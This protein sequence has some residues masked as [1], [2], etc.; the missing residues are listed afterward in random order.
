MDDKII[1]GI[2]QVGVGVVD[3]NAAM[4]WYAT[5][6][7]ADVLVFEDHEEATYMAPYMGGKAR[8]KSAALIMNLYGGAGYEVWQHTGRKP[9][10]PEQQILVGDLGINFISIK[11]KD[12]HRSFDLLKA[13]GVKIVSAVSKAP[14]GQLSFFIEDP[15]G[16]IIQVK[17]FLS[18]FSHKKTN[19]GG[20]YSC[21]LGVS[22]IDKTSIL[23]SDILGYNEVV[24][25]ET[26][27]FDD[28]ASLEGGKQKMRRLLLKTK[29]AP[30]G[31]FSELLGESQIELIQVIDRSPK[32][33]FEGRYWGDLGYIHLCFDMKNMPALVKECKEKGFPFSILSN[34]NFDMGD[35]NGDW[36]YLEDPDGTLIEFVQVNRIPILKK[37]NWYINLRNRDPKKPLPRLLVKAMKLNKVKV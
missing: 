16:N 1:Y 35:A 2:Q 10:A 7:G 33:I 24:Y 17:E 23:F 25:D 27:Y 19:V 34:P 20:I 30:T 3:V 29:Y 4:K 28:L 31:G 6:L 11:S 5:H 13:K 9:L 14:D 12:A 36:G 32:K 21:I 18:W 37:L 15:Y 22:D 26:G 8:K